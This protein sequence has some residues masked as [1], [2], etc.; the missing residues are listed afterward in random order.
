MVT[1]QQI[2]GK[3]E[4]EGDFITVESPRTI[5]KPE[6]GVIDLSAFPIGGSL[7]GTIIIPANHVIVMT[8]LDDSVETHYLSS[9][10]GLTL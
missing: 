9:I 7:K 4:E 2:I 6:P 3:I 10:T 5:I 8:D 1:G